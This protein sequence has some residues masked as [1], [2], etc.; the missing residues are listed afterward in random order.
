MIDLIEQ[1]RSKL[2][3]LCRKYHVRALE[4]FG[5][6]AEGTF[7][8]ARSDLDFLLQFLPEAAS[9]SFY[10]YFD[11]KEELGQLFGRKVDLKQ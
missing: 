7:D 3:M 10:G 6:A 4:L 2:E 11:L 5:S 8:L 9:R 1:H